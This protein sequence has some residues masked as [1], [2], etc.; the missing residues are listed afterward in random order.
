MKNECEKVGIR[1]SLIPF[2]II[3]AIWPMALIYNT[4]RFYFEMFEPGTL[5]FAS[6]YALFAKHQFVNELFICILVEMIFLII[7]SIFQIY[8]FINKDYRFPKLFIIAILFKAFSLVLITLTLSTIIPDVNFFEKE[9][10][11]NLFDYR[12]FETTCIIY[13]L[14]SKR[15]KATFVNNMPE[16]KKAAPLESINPE[17]GV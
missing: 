2:A 3:T 8:L 7:Y 11:K 1:G 15:V 4:I 6:E 17:T 14:N 9:I 12:I 10:F 13:L 16:R 5:N